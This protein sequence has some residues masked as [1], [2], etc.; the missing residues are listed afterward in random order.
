MKNF[1][2]ILS[3]KNMVISAKD[4]VI[5]KV[6][7]EIEDLIEENTRLKKYFKI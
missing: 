4:L 3:D 6:S 2:Q 5:D 1:K 7:K